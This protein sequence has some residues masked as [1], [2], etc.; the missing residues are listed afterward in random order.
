MFRAI[1]EMWVFKIKPEPGF[2]GRGLVF[3]LISDIRLLATADRKSAG[4]GTR[5][6]KMYTLKI[7]VI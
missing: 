3:I 4:S 1:I 6:G 2:S 7:I 5:L